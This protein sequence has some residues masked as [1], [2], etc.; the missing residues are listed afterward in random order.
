MT[1]LTKSK[2]KITHS[3][4]TARAIIATFGFKANLSEIKI[5]EQIKNISLKWKLSFS[6]SWDAY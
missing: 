5:P 4:D 1:Y 6:D 3:C 2:Y